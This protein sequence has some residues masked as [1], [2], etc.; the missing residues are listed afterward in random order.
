METAALRRRLHGCSRVLY[1]ISLSV[2]SS[3]MDW[4]LFVDD[5]D[6]MNDNALRGSQW[7]RLLGESFPPILGGTPE[8]WAEANRI[9]VPRLWEGYGLSGQPARDYTGQ[10][11]AYRTA[12]PWG[13]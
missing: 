13:R 8:A 10:G 9:V 3:L 5:G 7:Q 11:R 4:V 12:W 1:V 2:G 6:V